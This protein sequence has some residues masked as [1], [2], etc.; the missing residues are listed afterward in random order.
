STALGHSASHKEAAKRFFKERARIHPDPKE[1]V[2]Y[3]AYYAIYN[4]LYTQVE[5]LY[6][7]ISSISE[8]TPTLPPWDIDRLIHLLFKLHE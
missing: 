7:E 1:A 8:L 4:K 2:V 5:Q 3:D 6:E